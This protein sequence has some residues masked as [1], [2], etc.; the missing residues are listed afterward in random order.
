M[1]KSSNGN[2]YVQLIEAND[3]AQ[4]YNQYQGMVEEFKEWFQGKEKAKNWTT[5]SIHSTSINAS[6]RRES[7]IPLITVS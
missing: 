7:K 5:A 4:K 1:I 6:K 3:S 2:D